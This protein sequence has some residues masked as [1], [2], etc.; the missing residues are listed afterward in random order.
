MTFPEWW[1]RFRK[2]NKLQD[3][4]VIRIRASELRKICENA[5]IH[6]REDTKH[7]F[8]KDFFEGFNRK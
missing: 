8:I 3:D 2:K 4:R 6:T 7:D 5:V 1:E